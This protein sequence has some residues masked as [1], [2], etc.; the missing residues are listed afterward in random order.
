VRYARA[1]PAS[2]LSS[3]CLQDLKRLAQELYNQ[4]L[5]LCI[6]KINSSLSSRRALTIPRSNSRCW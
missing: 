5:I 4:F 1:R 6:P 2:A 3:R